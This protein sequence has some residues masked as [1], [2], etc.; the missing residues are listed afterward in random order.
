[1][2]TLSVAERKRLARLQP[3]LTARK[4]A[5]SAAF[6]EARDACVAIEEQIH[7]INEALATTAAALDA[8]DLMA[9]AAFESW[10]AAQKERLAALDIRL[11]QA[12]ELLESRRAAL[13]RSNGEVEALKRLLGV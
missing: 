9:R 5:D 1:M 3:A 8:S 6:A 13:A 11:R 7:A 12:E 4:N 2:K 10:R